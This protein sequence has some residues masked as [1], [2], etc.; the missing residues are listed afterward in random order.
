MRIL[1]AGMAILALSAWA[2]EVQF[3]AV[4]R[5]G[6][7]FEVRVVGVA[8]AEGHVTLVNLRTGEVV[9]LALRMTEG[10]LTTGL[11]YVNR[12]CEAPRAG[13]VVAQAGDILVAATELG[14]GL[15]STA[16]V[17]PRGRKSGEPRLTLERWDNEQLQWVPASDLIPARYRIRVEDAGRDTSC[18]KDRAELSFMVGERTFPIVLGETTATSGVFEG[19]LALV[20]EP[21][22][23]SLWVR[24]LTVEGRLMGEAPA[25]GVCAV[26]PVDGEPLRVPL[27]LF[28]VELS[29]PASGVA[30]GC[31][32]EVHVK[33]PETPDEVW[34][35]VDGVRRPSGP[36]LSL[37]A[38]V[39]Q[40]VQVTAL[41]RQGLMWAQVETSVVMWPRAQLSFVDAESGLPVTE[42]W[43]CAN[44]FK[45]KL[46]NV[47]PGGGRL[48]VGKLGPEPQTREL[49]LS[50]AVGG[51][52][53]S[54]PLRAADFL[55]CAGDVLWAQYRDPTGCYTVYVLL[56]LR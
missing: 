26:C 49:P 20:I 56:P 37:C 51:T 55:A 25:V 47:P 17:E 50:E 46:E 10:T 40:T 41:V 11:V 12:P 28:P 1:W 52:Y 24:L 5:I 14:G 2:A 21:K 44:P 16:R 15:A 39:P 3:T 36:G 8:E 29:V 31:C 13:A 19:E 4:P 30:V 42:P 7:E 45:V 34:W 43:L 32:G 38:E 54:G 53:L 48:L 27:S 22:D 6:G 33:V 18:E 23:C 9:R 35:C